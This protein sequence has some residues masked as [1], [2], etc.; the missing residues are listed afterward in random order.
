MLSSLLPVAVPG[1]GVD[2]ILA[3]GDFSLLPLVNVPVPSPT[4]PLARGRVPGVVRVGE[5]VGVT[6]PEV[7]GVG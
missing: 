1:D 7:E 5:V 4:P 2:G 3:V 6:A